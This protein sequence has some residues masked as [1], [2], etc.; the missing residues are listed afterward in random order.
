MYANI[1]KKNVRKLI[2][3]ER[4]DN[5]KSRYFSD[6]T[7]HRITSSCDSLLKD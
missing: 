5:Y 2:I 3:W 6:F 1:F 7:V 4:Q